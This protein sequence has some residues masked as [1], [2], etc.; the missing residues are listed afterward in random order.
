MSGNS[1]GTVT[2][3]NL[4]PEVLDPVIFHLPNGSDLT[5]A[6][7][8]RFSEKTRNHYFTASKTSSPI[9]DS[10]SDAKVAEI[11]SGIT[12]EFGDVEVNANDVKRTESRV[13]G[14]SDRAVQSGKAKSGDK[15][16]NTGGKLMR[17][18]TAEITVAEFRFQLVI[19]VVETTKGQD[20][21]LRYRVKTNT[22][23]GGGDIGEATGNAD[24]W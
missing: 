8:R 3:A 18:F 17:S 19:T 12:V 21:V 23:S 5:I 20:R 11:L 15:V 2:P 10:V 6:A 4:L 14:P 13:Y 1:A 7:V 22:R 16:P 9:P 24:A